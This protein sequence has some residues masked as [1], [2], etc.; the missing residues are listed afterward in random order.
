MERRLSEGKTRREVMR[1][2]KRYV[3][4]EV[5]QAIQEGASVPTMAVDA[6]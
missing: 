4:R 1:C 2:L 3:V 5:F 6:A